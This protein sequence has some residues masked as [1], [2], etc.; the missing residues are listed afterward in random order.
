MASNDKIL[1]HCRCKLACVSVMKER[2]AQGIVKEGQIAGDFGRVGQ[3][4][5]RVSTGAGQRDTLL[6]YHCISVVFAIFIDENSAEER[7]KQ[8]AE[9]AAEQLKAR[10]RT[11]RVKQTEISAPETSLSKSTYSRV[12]CYWPI[13]S[14]RA[15]LCRMQA[16][17]MVHQN[18]PSESWGGFLPRWQYS[19]VAARAGCCGK[20]QRT[21]LIPEG[22]LVP[23][24]EQHSAPAAWSLCAPYR[25]A[26]CHHH[27]PGL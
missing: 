11:V 3:K 10:H 2:I 15:G 18:I 20:V 17:V 25:S 16:Y 4:E 5:H 12:K 27:L 7:Q 23:N 6:Q 24:A 21:Q 13:I 14:T 8:G 1:S 9:Q 26:S 22:D 19:K